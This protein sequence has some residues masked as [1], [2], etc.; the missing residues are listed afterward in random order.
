MKVAKEEIRVGGDEEIRVQR[1]SAGQW[2]RGVSLAL[3]PCWDEARGG[4]C[5]EGE[6]R[7][8]DC[9]DAGAMAAH[10]GEVESKAQI[11]RHQ[12]DETRAMGHERL[13]RTVGCDRL[14]E[15]HVAGGCA[16]AMPSS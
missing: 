12:F 9:L 3:N 11:V 4:R 13:H 15:R 16:W 14:Q 2:V 5:E 1:L 8:E 6:D 10:G 7:T